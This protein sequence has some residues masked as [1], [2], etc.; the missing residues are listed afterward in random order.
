MRQK[1]LETSE[2][3]KQFRSFP[4]ETQVIIKLAINE[5]LRV[6]S[7]ALTRGPWLKA[8]G[9]GL[10]EFRIGKTVRAVL[11]KASVVVDVKEPK[12]PILVRIFCTFEQNTIYLLSC[13]DKL[14]EG[15]GKKQQQAIRQARAQLLT[16]KR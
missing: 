2:F 4:E 3:D 9:G 1:L 13:Y 7:L 12:R 14:R 5:I 10:Y 8:L 11:S 16:L 15:A 6:E